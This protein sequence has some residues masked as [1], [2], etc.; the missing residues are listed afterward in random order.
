MTLIRTALTGTFPTTTAL[1]RHGSQ[2]FVSRNLA[3]RLAQAIIFFDTRGE[4]SFTLVK[5]TTVGGRLHEV[6]CNPLHLTAHILW[7][8]SWLD[9]PGDSEM[10]ALFLPQNEMRALHLLVHSKYQIRVET[11][12]TDASPNN[13]ERRKLLTTWTISWPKDSTSDTP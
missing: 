13:P 9:R 5:H 6:T 12:V 3:G 7:A 8:V 11:K 1:R 2:A 4:T 10:F